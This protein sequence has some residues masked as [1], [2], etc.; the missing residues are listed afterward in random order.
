MS[1]IAL[2]IVL[3]LIGLFVYLLTAFIP[4]PQQFKTLIVVVAIVIALLFVL[5]A[6]GFLGAISSVQ[7]PRVR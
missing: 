6:L 3:A 5:Q 4:M 1:L 2:L 7:V